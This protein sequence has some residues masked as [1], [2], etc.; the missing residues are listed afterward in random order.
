MGQQQ[1]LMH[2]KGVQVSRGYNHTL[3]K[4]KPLHRTSSASSTESIISVGRTHRT[5][6][7]SSGD[8]TRRLGREK[9]NNERNS[10]NSS[11][12]SRHHNASP[13]E[14]VQVI[15][16]RPSSRRRDNLSSR[17][18]STEDVR[19]TAVYTAQHRS[20]RST[21]GKVKPEVIR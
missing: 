7:S 11:K 14:A 6:L 5:K 16:G 1:K 19:A 3:H 10:Q 4:I 17:E 9:S 21:S 8:E 15:V 20:R 18:N 13:S 2:S 12:S